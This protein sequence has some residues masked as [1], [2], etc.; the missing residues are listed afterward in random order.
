MHVAWNLLFSWEMGRVHMGTVRHYW[1]S[2][3]YPEAYSHRLPAFFLLAFALKALISPCSGFLLKLV[4]RFVSF[5][6]FLT[7]VGQVVLQVAAATNCKHHYGV[8]KA[9]IPAKYAEVRGFLKRVV[10]MCLIWRLTEWFG[11]TAKCCA[12]RK[13]AFQSWLLLLLGSV[14]PGARRARGKRCMSR[15]LLAVL[16]ECAEGAWAC[17]WSGFRTGRCK[18]VLTVMA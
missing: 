10:C 11:I 5:F 6:V 16:A 17:F 13:A 2:K 18:A 1:E 12:G 4:L 7:G 3:L 14:T 15:R 9:D 8:E